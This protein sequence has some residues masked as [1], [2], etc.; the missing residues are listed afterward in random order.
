M[1]VMDQDPDEFGVNRTALSII[2]GAPGKAYLNI[3]YHTIVS[4]IASRRDFC[5]GKCVGDDVQEYKPSRIRDRQ[6]G[7]RYCI[8]HV[9]SITRWRHLPLAQNSQRVWSR[10]YSAAASSGLL[11]TFPISGYPA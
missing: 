9:V 4:D 5:C 10:K 7:Y 3:F 6:G 11:E 1:K 8:G 2:C